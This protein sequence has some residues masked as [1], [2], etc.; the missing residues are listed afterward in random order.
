LFWKPRRWTRRTVAENI[1]KL[2]QATWPKEESRGWVTTTTFWVSRDGL[3]ILY[4]PS[5]LLVLY[6]PMAE[7]VTWPNHMPELGSGL[8][9]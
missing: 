9:L 3:K 2:R 5:I 1:K 7:Q 4:P 8:E 6:D